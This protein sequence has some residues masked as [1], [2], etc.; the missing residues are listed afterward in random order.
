M[1]PIYLPLRDPSYLT[2]EDVTRMI[3]LEPELRGKAF[4][5]LLAR[6]GMRVSEAIQL[7]ESDVD[8]QRGTLTIVHQKEK[9]KLKCPHC[10]GGLGKKHVWCPGCGN[11]V[12][13]ALREKI[14]QQRKRVIPADQG[15]LQLLNEYLEW[16]KSNLRHDP[17]LFPFSRQRGWQIAE[18]AGRRI[19]FKGLHPHSLRHFLATTWLN[20]GLDSKKLQVML[21][22]ANFSTTMIYVDTNQEQLKSEYD[23]LWEQK[24]E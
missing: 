14:E 3:A 8:F 15:T 2:P 17:L 19:G 16:R 10:K 20:K 21:G 24:E 6:T 11:K 18:E 13:Q 9:I 5:T 4:L 12:G 23:K 7:K 1:T 22:H